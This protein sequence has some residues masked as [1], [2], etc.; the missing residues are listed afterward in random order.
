VKGTTSTAQVFTVANTGNAAMVLTGAPLFTGTNPTEFAID[1]PTTT[2]ALTAGASLAAGQSCRIG[3]VFK[4]AAA[5]VRSAYVLLHGNTVTGTNVIRVAGTATLPTP[6]V[7]ITSPTGSVSKGTTVTFS[8]SVTTALT[9]KPTG[10]VTFKVNNVAIGSPVTL[11][12]GGTASTTFTEST[13]ATYSLSATYN[14]DSNFA[15]VTATK[16]LVVNVVKAAVNVNLAPAVEPATACG[17]ASFT[18]RVT[19][20]TGMP[21]GTVQLKSDSAVVGS[22]VLSDGV[23]TMTGSR[24]SPGPHSFV[25]SYGGDDLHNAGTSAA[26]SRTLPSGGVCNAVVAKV[27]AQ[28]L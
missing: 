21:T 20:P 14:G 15:P 9:T 27:G 26:V 23:A 13:A 25:A 2:C 8:V 7:S 16:S 10:T 4:P 17:T 18:V 5:G 6:T 11:S 1:A 12:A 3:I 22:A 28:G 19:S 24:Q